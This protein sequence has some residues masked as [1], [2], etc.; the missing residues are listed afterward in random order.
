MK[1]RYK[2]LNKEKKNN[3]NIA[4]LENLPIWGFLYYRYKKYRPYKT[5][6]ILSVY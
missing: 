4:W 2:M 1:K 3:F 6:F 5:L